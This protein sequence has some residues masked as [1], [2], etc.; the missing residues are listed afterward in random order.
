MLE[1]E[2]GARSPV[3]VLSLPPGNL[4]DRQRAL[5]EQLHALRS[6]YSLQRIKLVGHGVGGL[7]AYLLLCERPLAAPAFSAEDAALVADIAHVVTVGAPLLGTTLSGTGALPVPF[8]LSLAREL[9]ADL[10]AQTRTLMYALRTPNK[11]RA[12]L[13]ALPHTGCALLVSVLRNR[14][15]W[16]E[17]TPHALRTVASYTARTSTAKLSCYASYVPPTLPAGG[18]RLFRAL[19]ERTSSEARGET[20]DPVLLNHCKLLERAPRVGA[21]EQGSLN[22]DAHS[23]DGLV[24]TLRQLPPDVKSH[25]VAALVLGDHADLLGYFGDPQTSLPRTQST[26]REDQLFELLGKIARELSAS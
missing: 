13:A 26:F 2:T 11:R 5:L 12:L 9:A 22:L 19:Y 3:V 17:L 18:S 1:L 14:S 15:L 23:N 10:R 25:E 7:D 8:L 21:F 20:R 16:A 4:V 6:Q 24:N